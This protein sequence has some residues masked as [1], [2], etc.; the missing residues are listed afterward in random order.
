MQ[1]ADKACQFAEIFWERINRKSIIWFTLEIVKRSEHFWLWQRYKT[2][3]VCRLS[4]FIFWFILWVNYDRFPT[5]IGLVVKNNGKRQIKRIV[6]GCGKTAW[7]ISWGTPDSTELYTAKIICIIVALKTQLF[8]IHG[9]IWKKSRQK[10]CPKWFVLFFM[11]I[12]PKVMEKTKSHLAELSE[13]EVDQQR[14]AIF[15]EFS[16]FD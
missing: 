13:E 7:R 2:M 5:Q 9:Q 1:K 14:K 10:S 16:P 11:L 12:L 15:Q 6:Q 3:R 4:N 8:Y